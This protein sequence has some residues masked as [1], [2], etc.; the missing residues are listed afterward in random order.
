MLFLNRHLFGAE[1]GYAVNLC[2]TNEG[3]CAL[4]YEAAIPMMAVPATPDH[5]GPTNYHA[6]PGSRLVCQLVS[7][8]GPPGAQLSFWEPAQ[9]MPSFSLPVGTSEGTNCFCISTNQ[10]EP[11][12]DPYGDVQGRRFAVTEPGLYRL[13]FQL[14]DSSSNGPGGGPIHAPSEMCFVYLQAGR[15]IN[16]TT[17]QGTTVAISFGGESGRNFYLERTTALGP[18]AQWVPVAGPILGMDRLQFLADPSPAPQG[19]YRLR[20]SVPRST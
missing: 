2:F 9:S 20:G 18:G 4:Q 1:S 14:I 13:G 7:L 19:F 8:T 10:G 12:C 17:I 5:A 6:A 15:L 11:A 3:P 16:S